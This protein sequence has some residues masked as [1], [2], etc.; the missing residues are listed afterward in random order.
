MERKKILR[1]FKISH[2]RNSGTIDLEIKIVNRDRK[3][4]ILISYLYLKSWTI[5]GR[6]FEIHLK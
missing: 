3:N 2:H 6:I 5:P 4:E 1:F